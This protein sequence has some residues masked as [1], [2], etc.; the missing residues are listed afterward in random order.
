MSEHTEAEQDSVRDRGGWASLLRERFVALDLHDAVTDGFRGDVAAW[1]L[2][3]L[4]LA[5]V[6]SVPQTLRRSASVA[7]VGP[8]KLFGSISPAVG[9]VQRGGFQPPR[10]QRC[11]TSST[12]GSGAADASWRPPPLVLPRPTLTRSS[13]SS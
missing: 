1:A 4:M 12:P 3:H 11:P 10:D 2:G 7:S 13:A 6:G 8:V 9:L 5:R